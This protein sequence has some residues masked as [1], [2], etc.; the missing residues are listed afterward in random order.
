M[1]RE[2]SLNKQ[3]IVLS[4]VAVVMSL[5]VGIGIPLLQSSPAP[6]L[7]QAARNLPGPT[8]TVTNTI[9]P[10]PAS[11]ALSADMT[12]GA[13]IAWQEPGPATPSSI[14]LATSTTGP[15]PS[16]AADAPLAD[17]AGAVS[18]SATASPTA[19]ATAKSEPTASATPTSTGRPR[20]TATPAPTSKAT[21]PPASRPADAA[22]PASSRTAVASL[23]SPVVTPALSAPAESAALV[24]PTRRPS[25]EAPATDAPA[26]TATV[27][28]A[29]RA[30][31]PARPANGTTAGATAA[32]PTTPVASQVWPPVVTPPALLNPALQARLSGV[33]Q[34]DWFPTSM[35]PVGAYYEIVVWSPEQ[36][37][38]QAWGVAPPRITTSLTLNL[39]ELFR[40]GRF[41]EGSLYWTVLVV[42]QN[43]YR[44][45]TLPAE[46]ER[47]YLV[48]ATGG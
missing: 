45:L 42:E 26:P 6:R 17:R 21:M 37:P 11:A 25:I 10:D 43:P 38:N 18:L 1:W 29:A 39:D 31:P 41:R 32:R 16:R 5:V 47:R 8:P 7:E 20:D 30:N 13:L 40:S 34:F 35:L 14:P 36:D 4:L 19:T 23:S 28:Q 15:T 44:R 46:S 27:S 9:P 48:L 3:S 22:Q 24:L 33:V 2:F 12:G